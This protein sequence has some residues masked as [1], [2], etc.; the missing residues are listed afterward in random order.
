MQHEQPSAGSSATQARKSA[1]RSSS[2]PKWSWWSSSALST[3]AARGRRRAS[4]PS[5][6]SASATHEPAG[7]HARVG[8]EL[9]HVAADQEG[10]ILA[11]LLEHVGDQRGRARLAVRAGHADPSPE[12]TMSASTS[13]RWR[14]RRPCRRARRRAP[15]RL[16]DR[17]RDD[18]LHA[19]PQ[20]RGI[21][22][23]ARIDALGAQLLDGRRRAVAA[24]DGA[25]VPAQ[26]ARDARHAGAADA[27]QVQLA[28]GRSR[29]R[30][31]SSRATAAAASGRA[32]L[33]MPSRI[34]ARRPA[35]RAARRRARATPRRR[36]R[37]PRRSRHRRQRR[38][39]AHSRADGRPWHADRVRAARAD[40]PLRA[41]TPCR[42]RGSRRGRRQPAPSR[43]DRG[44]RE[45]AV[46]V[47]R[48]RHGPA[49]PARGPRPGDVQDDAVFQARRCRTRRRRRR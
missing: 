36:A 29:A 39:S 16:V 40:R 13:E 22:P 2:E 1:W 34:A 32:T 14:T 23:D 46:A 17:A 33:R 27:E 3:I 18:Q 26:H 12:A 35:R 43:S 15:A 47:G 25:A 7:A 20:V 8:A 6:S 41:P 42:R 21:V 19:G 24:R 9:R 30:R 4:E 28:H 10:R 48:R 45:H 44:R 5:D 37:R 31:R 38:N 11:A 49:S